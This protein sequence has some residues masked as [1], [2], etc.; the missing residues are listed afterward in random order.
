MKGKLIVRSGR[1]PYKKN[2][3]ARRKHLAKDLV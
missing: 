3:E 2:G 1:R